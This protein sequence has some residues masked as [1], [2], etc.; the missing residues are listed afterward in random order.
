MKLGLSFDKTEYEPRKPINMTLT[1]K[2]KT[3]KP[4]YV[5]KRFHLNSKESP[6]G[7][8]EVYL[9]VISPSGKELPCKVSNTDGFPRTDELVLLEPGREVSIDRQKGINGFFD[10]DEPGTYKITATYENVYGEEIGVD[11][12]KGRIKSKRVKIVILEKK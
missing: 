9:I 10:F 6:R 11:A 1:L 7:E 2:N 3:R 5:N 12:F 8:K 4:I